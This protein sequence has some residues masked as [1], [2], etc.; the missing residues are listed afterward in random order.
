[1]VHVH[2]QQQALGRG[3]EKGEGGR[4]ENTELFSARYST[5]TTAV[6][7]VLHKCLSMALSQ[8]VG[9]CSQELKF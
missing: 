5:N 9:V 8:L 4:E 2:E 7:G 1:M 3:R 6:S